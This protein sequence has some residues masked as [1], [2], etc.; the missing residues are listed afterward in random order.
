MPTSGMQQWGRDAMCRPLDASL[1]LSFQLPI[2]L[3]F[4]K[5]QLIGG[6]DIPDFFCA[7]MRLAKWAQTLAQVRE[8][9]C[10]L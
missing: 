8:V 9:I 10:E 5:C 7:G 3:A 1:R 6:R 4:D 2:T